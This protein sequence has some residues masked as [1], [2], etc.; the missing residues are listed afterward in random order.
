MWDTG[1]EVGHRFA[2]LAPIIDQREPTG[3]AQPRPEAVASVDA[4]HRC[5]RRCNRSDGG[6]AVRLLGADEPASWLVF[7][8][9]LVWCIA[10]TAGCAS[11]TS[12]PFA[13]P[14]FTSITASATA[15]GGIE[16]DG[17][18]GADSENTSA[19][20]AD[21]TSGSGPDT[22]SDPTGSPTDPLPTGDTGE[23]TQCQSA[24]DC[25]DGDS[26][27]EDTCEATGICAHVPVVCD[28]GLD[29][30]ADSCD[31]VSGQCVYEPDDALCDDGDACTGLETCDAVAGCVEG[32]PVVCSD[33]QACT[34]DQCNPADGSCSYPQVETCQSGD[35]CCPLGCSVQE[36]DDCTCTNIAPSATPTSSGG[37]D[38]SAGYGPSEWTDGVDEAGC[39]AA[40][41]SQCF[42]WISNN[43]TP[44]GAYMQLSWG[45]SQVIGSMVL[46]ANGAVESCSGGNGRRPYSGEVQYWNGAA[47]V[48]SGYTWNAIQGD[49]VFDFDPPL[50]TTQLRLYNVVTP[51]GGYNSL[52]YEWYVYEPL[53][54]TP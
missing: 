13:K 28:D 5:A 42:G 16:T 6:D 49:I 31:P 14:Q 9:A 29:C 54:C 4:R 53:G 18:E 24:A 44:N 34:L 47:W 26:C 39:A 52:A 38:N 48:A 43:A 37:G 41:C 12:D 19:G 22:G 30:T 50:Q 36:D 33:G 35:G 3:R 11:G 40:G 27:T 21:V 7:G 23:P 10:A 25:D 45:S 32:T 1:V 2:D 51:P 17:T 8:P 20:S 46:D 15:S